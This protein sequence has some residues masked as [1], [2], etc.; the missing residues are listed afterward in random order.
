MTGP[1]GSRTEGPPRR[2]GPPVFGPS[3]RRLLVRVALVR[4][5][6]VR[7]VGDALVRIGVDAV[8]ERALLAFEEA[9]ARPLLDVDDVVVQ[10]AAF[11][12]AGVATAEN[13]HPVRL[14]RRRHRQ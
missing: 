12:E 6:D 8:A 5:A 7:E 1:G 2:A 11:R 4:H 3:V 10:P 14:R 13:A 9:G